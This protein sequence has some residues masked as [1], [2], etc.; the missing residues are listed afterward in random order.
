MHQADT[1]DTARRATRNRV[2]ATRGRRHMAI[3]TTAD[4]DTALPNTADRNTA[5]QATH[6]V[7]AHRRTAHRV[8]ARPGPEAKS[9]ARGHGGSACR[10]HAVPTDHPAQAAT[11][12]AA[13]RLAAAVRSSA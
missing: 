1:A 5:P 9:G 13:A 7:M 8:T 2:P 4:R 3:R 12:R 11:V 6:Q 10:S